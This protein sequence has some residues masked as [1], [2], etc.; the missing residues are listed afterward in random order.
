[1][2]TTKYYPEIPANTSLDSI[3]IVAGAEIKNQTNL[4]NG[5]IGIEYDLK[6]GRWNM[7]SVPLEVKSS[8]FYFDD[9]PQVG[10]QT[11]TPA[12]DNA[13]WSNIADLDTTFVPGS[14]FAYKIISEDDDKKFTVGGTVLADEVT[15]EVLKFGNDNGLNTCFALAGNPF[16]TTIDFDSLQNA[17]SGIINAS[18][19]IWTEAG[20]FSGY[21]PDG[22][23]GIV[24]TNLDKYIAPLQSFIIEKSETLT[25]NT[26]NLAFDLSTISAS[27]SGK[28]T[29]KSTANNVN[30]L[31]I[32][33][34]NETASVLTFIANRENGKDSRKLKA[35]ISS[36]PDVYTLKNE[37]ALGANIIETEE[38]SIPIGLAT[39]YEGTM[40]FTFNGMENYDARITLIDALANVPIDL[41]GLSSHEYSFVYTPKTE[42]GEVVPDEDR[43]VLQ[44]SPKGAGLNRDHSLTQGIFISANGNTI[45]AT[46][47]PSDKIKEVLVY[48][49]Q[50]KLVYAN[51]Q[52]DTSLFTINNTEYA[53][54]CI[55]KVITENNVK[56]GKVIVK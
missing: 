9:E 41:T 55:V 2:E 30:K 26:A 28:G 45:R 4:V 32:I 11:F 23:W 25:G 35:A 46:S 31:N 54:V 17:N 42:N 50:G 24:D 16:L 37:I 51:N 43:F 13:Q 12:E 10:L 22:N 8:A 1:M 3:F 44:I 39:N 34:T 29:W 38:T 40:S 14:G 18:Y 5:K 48:N 27:A 33:A 7:L 15:E 53:G 36:V 6:A 56:N 21:N 19:L 52:L 20:G 49:T 47:L